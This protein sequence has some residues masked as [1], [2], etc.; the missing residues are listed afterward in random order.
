[1]IQRYEIGD[2]VKTGSFVKDVLYGGMGIVYILDVKVGK[3]GNIL[4]VKVGKDENTFAM[5]TCD[6]QKLR[7]EE[8]IE[9]IKTECLIWMSLPPHPNIVKAIF[10]EIEGQIPQLTMEYA[11][12]GNLRRRLSS[13]RIALTDILRITSEVCEGMRFLSEEQGVVHRDLKPE[14]ILFGS[15]GAA[16]ITDFGLAVAFKADVFLE[17]EAGPGSSTPERGPSFG[18]TAH[19]MAPEQFRSFDDVDARADIYALGVVLYEMLAQRL[20]FDGG[21]LRS[22]EAAHRHKIPPPLPIEVPER[23]RRLVMRCL[24]KDPDSRFRSFDALGQEIADCCRDAGMAESIAKRHMTSDLEA[25][26][27]SSDWNNRGFTFVQLHRFDEALGAYQRGIERAES[28][29]DDGLTAVTP[30]V[31]KVKSSKA[32]S[33]T[34]LY[35]N[36]GAALLRMGRKREARVALNNALAVSPE[37]GTTHYLLAQMEFAEGNVREGLALLKRSTDCEPGNFDLLLKYLRACYKFGDPAFE[38]AFEEF[39]QG[40]RNEPPFLVATGCLLEETIGPDIA[41]RC[42]DTA[43]HSDP[44]LANAWYN[45]GVT[46]HRYGK[47]AQALECYQHTLRLNRDHAL[48]RCY[49]GLLELEQGKTEE[50]MWNLAK[51]IELDPS[52]T[53]AGLIRKAFEGLQLGIPLGITLAVFSSPISIW[54]LA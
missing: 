11:P 1:M 41:L 7:S 38:P 50:A 33:L 20:P 42:F 13:G 40:K 25:A 49:L 4:D 27:H 47:K 22:L 9:R 53:Q 8:G 43:L 3:G 16:K 5:K 48:A 30:G 10:F 2:Q 26:L 51:F 32:S 28:E 35:D 14:N 54:H 29:P 34:T 37:D 46:L 52:S 15:D 31:E 39:L 24:E 19:Y 44:D 36:M 23:L 12:G 18:G 17:D 6:L 21:S 45:K